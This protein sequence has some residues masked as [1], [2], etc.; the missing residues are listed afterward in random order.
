MWDLR[1]EEKI[2]LY[3]NNINDSTPFAVL[4]T[5]NQ[6]NNPVKFEELIK[7]DKLELSFR[8]SND[9]PFNFYGLKYN[10][11]IQLEINN[12]VEEIFI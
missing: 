8:D 3:I 11:N 1:I 2:Y 12:P 4:Y 9:R 6:G 10:L 7:L 5:N